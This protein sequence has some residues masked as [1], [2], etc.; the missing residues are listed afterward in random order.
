ME[1]SED[2]VRGTSYP[3]ESVTVFFLPFSNGDYKG[4]LSCF[5]KTTINE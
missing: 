2:V 3:L 5:L 1:E 4:S